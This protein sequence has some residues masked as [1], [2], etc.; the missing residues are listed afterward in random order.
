MDTFSIELVVEAA[1]MDSEI[2]MQGSVE[3]RING[4]KPYSDGD[5]VDFDVFVKS[6]D[7]EGEFFIFSCT[8]GIPECA[9]WI[10]GIDVRHEGN[11]ISWKNSNDN[12]S[13]QFDRSG[14]QESLKEIRREVLKYKKFFAKKEIKYVGVGYNW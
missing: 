7:V 5:Y 3:I 6:L 9:G 13:W 2:W 12:I 4:S 11:I 10:K 14:I 1:Q 8:C